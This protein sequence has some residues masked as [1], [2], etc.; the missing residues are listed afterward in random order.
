MADH[1]A[2]V[3][4]LLADYRRSRDQLAGVHRALAGISES[5]TSPCGLVTV[6]VS[7][8]GALTGLEI[9]D[10]AYRT[11]R[12][13]ELSTV[14]VRAAADAALKASRA[15]SDVVAPV[16]PAGTDPEAL[17]KGTADLTPAETTPDPVIDDES[18]EDVH[19]LES[20]RS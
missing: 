20:G 17:I 2:Q 13:H 14:I 16:L 15:M 9:A 19:W 11:Y 4:D 12:P 7:A 1:R 6:T 8:Q 18:F 10:T 5:A 3:E